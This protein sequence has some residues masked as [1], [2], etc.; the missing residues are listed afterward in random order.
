MGWKHH[1]PYKIYIYFFFKKG[2]D[3][4]DLRGKYGACV[5][6]VMSG[7]AT[8][9]SALDAYDFEGDT[10][11]LENALGGEANPSS[12]GR[13]SRQWVAEKYP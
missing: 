12:K 10:D 6:T 4:N 9:I 2:T 5:I 13:K 3:E 1:F 7:T 11:G 8:G